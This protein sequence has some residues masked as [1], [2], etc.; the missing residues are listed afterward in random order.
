MHKYLDNALKRIKEDQQ[1][2]WFNRVKSKIEELKNAILVRNVKSNDVHS[3][4]KK[5]CNV[6]HL[7]LNS[8]YEGT[9]WLCEDQEI[10]GIHGWFARIL[11]KSGIYVQVFKG[12]VP[13]K[14]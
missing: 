11:A 14:L 9:L 3:V 8:T 10:T 13:P 12:V 1:S 4:T 2:N 7:N 5:R 6:Y